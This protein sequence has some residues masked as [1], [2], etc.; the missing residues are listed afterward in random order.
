MAVFEQSPLLTLFVLLVLGYLVVSTLR[1]RRSACG[2]CPA[3]G[4]TRT[5]K[6]KFC[7]RCGQKLE[8]E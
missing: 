2:F 7:R 3:C 1:S 5:P 4:E 8:P 6:A